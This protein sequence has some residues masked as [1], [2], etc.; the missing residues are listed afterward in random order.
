MK[1]DEFKNKKRFLYELFIF[2]SDMYEDR[3]A[4]GVPSK[5]DLDAVM[6]Q[7]DTVLDW[8]N[9]LKKENTLWKKMN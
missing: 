6:R 9:E 3:R 1:E 5:E 8:Y 2:Y 4:S 7:I